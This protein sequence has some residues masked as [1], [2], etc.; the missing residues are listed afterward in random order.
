[1][2]LN[3]RI[4]FLFAALFMFIA[5]SQPPPP[6]PTVDIGATVEAAVERAFPTATHTPLPDFQATVQAG[7]AGTMEVL[8][9]VASPT[10]VPPPIPS[11]TPTPT[12]VP[13]VTPTSTSIP[14]ETPTLIPTNTP[15]P[16]LTLTATPTY[17]PTATF[18]PVPTATP[19]PTDTPTAVPTETPT[20]V[21]TATHTPAPTATPTPIP[22]P[23]STPLPTAA[24]APETA[25]T[26]ADVVEQA[27]ASVVRIEGATSS[28]SGFVVDS[29][30]YILTNEHVIRGQ[31]GLTVVLDDRTR[32]G[33]SVVASDAARDIALLKVTTSKSLTVLNF[34]T[35]VRAGDEV[36]AL[37]YPLD[38]D[39][40]LTV[41]KGIV[42]A[43]RTVRGVDRIQ[44]DAAIN[45]GNSGGPLLNVY[46]E[47]VGMNTSVQ[48]D[49]QG[50]EYFAQGIG[51]AIKFDVLSSRFTTMKAGQ[52]LPPPPMPTPV[53]EAT[54]TPSYIFG[55]VSGSIEHD[56]D[57]GFIDVHRA[58]VSIADAIIEARF[59]NPYS[60]QVGEWSSGFLFRKGQRNTFH[61]I[62]VS[63]NGAWYHNLRTGDVDAE[64]EL[65]A[66]FSSHIDTTAGGSNH[67]RV[68]TN[69]E[70]GWLFING[71][72]VSTLNL[73]D[74]IGSG[75]VSA[76]GSYYRGHGISGESTR[77][78]GYIIRR[79]SK[80]YGPGDG[81]IGHD[82]DDGFIDTYR[83]DTSLVDGI[84]EARFFNPY[85][86]SQGD[87]SSGFLIRKTDSN[88]FHVVVLHSSGR[89][90]HRLRTGDVVTQQNLNDGPAN[91]ASTSSLGSNHIQIIALGAN[92]WL[93]INGEFVDELDLS[94]WVTSGSV[95]A[96]ASYFMDDGI[97]GY[98]TR[99]E[100]F[101]I[102]SAD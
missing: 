74:L 30:G 37:G 26:L 18:T 94:G 64:H 21:P 22:P 14:T 97:S 84:I 61:V 78:E 102:W 56:P 92:G 27:R 52:V 45:P 62:V 28:G 15:T 29:D 95:S 85:D 67:I 90:Y 5:C 24:P 99:F 13:T 86:S 9:V 31:S 91:N 66:E 55:P 4:T 10:A 20:P 43:F 47:V 63:S 51:F 69:G 23:T 57:D 38:L 88:V 36:V 11:P 2:Q 34:A 32:L 53:V 96:V 76:I 3:M 35:S 54:Q 19:V 93:F 8:A 60:A 16:I 44:T 89:W 25:L 101:T 73:N 87:W 81:S 79:L 80:K 42:S 65:A 58:N 1:M 46:G 33:A 68:V 49:I 48:R 82:P 100:E 39:E 59:F 83:A 75:G 17:T 7:I 50:E 72:F 70:E 12:A 77:F 71:A 40:D 98:S 41:T 6:E